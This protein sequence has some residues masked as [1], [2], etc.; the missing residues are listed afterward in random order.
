MAR[1]ANTI[2]ESDKTLSIEEK[3]PLADQEAEAQKR[4]LKSALVI[5]CE[6]TICG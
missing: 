6:L 2:D 5:N 1:S 4:A 3:Q